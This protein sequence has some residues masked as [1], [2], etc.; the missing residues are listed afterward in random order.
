MEECFKQKLQ[1]KNSQQNKCTSGESMNKRYHKTKTI[2]KNVINDKTKHWIF[3]KRKTTFRLKALIAAQKKVFPRFTRGVWTSTEEI[4]EWNRP[5]PKRCA[6]EEAQER[7]RGIS[8]SSRSFFRASSYLSELVVR[9]REI[10]EVATRAQSPRCPRGAVAVKRR[11]REGL[12]AKQRSPSG[13]SRCR[14]CLLT[15]DNSSCRRLFL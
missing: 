5:I 11:E 9:R 10:C 3:E 15:C 7:M 14:F 6:G 2:Y 1:T 8:S 13:I 4:T 12:V